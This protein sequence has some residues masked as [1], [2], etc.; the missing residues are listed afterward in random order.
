VKPPSGDTYNEALL[1]DVEKKPLPVDVESAPTGNNKSILYHYDTKQVHVATNVFGTILSSI[2][3]LTSIIALSFV[4]DSRARLGLI[5]TFTLL[6]SSC[7][8]VAT[9]ARRVEIF[10]ATAA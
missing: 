2:A 7:L 8:A 6:F 4:T 5:C 3:P 1:I 10:A 9:K